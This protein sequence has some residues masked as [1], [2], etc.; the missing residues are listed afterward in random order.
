[1]AR[2]SHA[3]CSHASTK[4]ARAACRRAMKKVV[5]IPAIESPIITAWNAMKGGPLEL[6]AGKPVRVSF[7]VTPRELAA[8]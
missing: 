3:N 5:S 6:T 8:T 4:V 7:D 1:M 2:F